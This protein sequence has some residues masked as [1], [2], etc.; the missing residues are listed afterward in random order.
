MLEV[1]GNNLANVN[2]PGF[3]TART[4]FSDLMYDVQRGASSGTGGVLGSVNPM[5]I[6]TGSK[7]SAV[8]LNFQQ[9]NLEATGEQL[10]AAIDGGGFF[11]AHNGTNSVFTRKGAFSL[12]ENGYLVD[13]STGY[14]VQRF[15]TVGESDVNGVA[16]QTNGDSRIQVPLGAS[17]PGM[18][19]ESVSLTGQLG[20]S[21]T[22]PA[23]R[24]LRGATLSSATGPV[25][26]ATLLND[27]DSTT[28]NYGVGDQLV[29]SG[30]AQDGSQLNSTIAVDGTTTVQDLMNAIQT[31]FGADAT[32]SF[33]NS[34]IEIEST[35]VGPAG[36]NLSIDDH[37]S[38][39]GSSNTNFTANFDDVEPGR[40]ASS[41]Q[42]AFPIHDERGAQHS[43]SYELEKQIDGS[44]TLSFQLDGSSGVLVDDRVEGIRFGPD[45]SLS[46]VSGT[47]VGDQNISIHFAGSTL[48][49]TID[50]NLGTFGEIDGLAEIGGNPEISYDVD[51]SDPGELASVQIDADGTIQGIGSNGLRF[52][53]AQLAIA[54][55]RNVDGLTQAGSGYFS[56][57]LASGNP[58]IGTALSGD[59]GSIR[60]AQ[61]E[62]SNVD[63]ALEFTRL[64]VA[65]RGFSANARTITVTDEV[66][67]E[68]TNIIR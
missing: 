36:I 10:D 31:M 4:I 48:P 46:Q 19:T 50:I 54:S 66:L 13:A 60:S 14:L 5:Q 45:G 1:I 15:G 64:L 26:P 42:G 37:Q 40:F 58:E 35:Q 9:G 53:L 47:G 29:L 34:A 65:Q 8:D 18:V 61:L 33:T 67:E 27:L 57:S 38:N 25:T 32:V 2:T 43:L 28:D 52:P 51:G 63:L 62:G 24:L 44:W 17:L 6:G 68:L 39:V 12:D 20:A 56:T 22:G 30:Q 3:K 21:A 11:V 49:Q 7:V 41:I 55:F 59:R 16:F 23:N